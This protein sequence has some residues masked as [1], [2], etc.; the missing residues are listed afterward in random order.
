M[1]QREMISD[2][3]YRTSTQYRFFSFASSEALL[4]KRTKTNAHSHAQLPQETVYLTVDEE[5]EL[6]D[7]YVGKL[8]DLCRL[9]KVPSHV[10]V[11]T[12]YVAR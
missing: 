5:V 7:Y 11:H 6:V 12:S 1:F 4:A 3:Q 9:F 2:D 8:W 10:K